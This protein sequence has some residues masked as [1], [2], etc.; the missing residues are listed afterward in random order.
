MRR[1]GPEDPAAGCASSLRETAGVEGQDDDAHGLRGVL[2]AVADRH[3]GGG[4]GL[5]VAGSPRL[6][7][8]GCPC[9]NSQRIASI[10]R[11][12]R[13]RPTT[14]ESTIGMMT[15]STIVCPTAR[16]R[17]PRSVAPTRPPKSA[18]EEDEGRP[19]YQVIRFQVIAP[20]TPAKTTP[21]LV[22]RSGG[23]DQAVADGLG[24][25]GAEGAPTK[26]PTAASAARPGGSAPG[27][28]RW[29]RSRS[30]RRGSRWCSRSQ[31]DHDDATAMSSRCPRI[32][33]P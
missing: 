14:G 2:H 24:H 7:L 17:R 25:A 3:G 29:W 5:R 28:R 12:P 21:G 15:L 9:R 1:R 8:P 22:P 23:V 18:C 4:G 30:P 11:K 33:T 32:R 10:T 16:R 20:S 27:W 26:L 13:I 6:S 19:K 31:G